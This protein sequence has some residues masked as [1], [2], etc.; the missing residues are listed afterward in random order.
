[1]TAILKVTTH[2][3][4]IGCYS[5]A[6]NSTSLYGVLS[7]I[8]SLQSRVLVYLYHQKKYLVNL[9]LT[10]FNILGS[11]FRKHSVHISETYLSLKHIRICSMRSTQICISLYSQIWSF[12]YRPI[13]FFLKIKTHI[14]L[15][16]LLKSSN[17]M[18]KRFIINNICNTTEY[19]F[20]LGKNKQS[21]Y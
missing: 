20:S 7:S 11:E 9:I 17:Y 4:L 1:M 16:F 15:N 12:C 19:F 8:Y 6:S 3:S 21:R 13:T 2:F 18:F 5:Y 14:E 10:F